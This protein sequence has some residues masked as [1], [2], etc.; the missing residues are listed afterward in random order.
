MLVINLSYIRKN[1]TLLLGILITLFLCLALMPWESQNPHVVLVTSANARLLPIYAVDA[2][3][4]KIAISF[5]ATWGAEETPKILAT[6]K[7]YNIKTTFFLVNIWLKKFP[8]M[9]KTIA[10]DGHEIGMHST[11]HPYF[12]KLSSEQMK[13][14]LRDNHAMIKQIC[15]YDAKLFRPPFGDYDNRVIATVNELGFQT[16]QWSADS[17][18]W[19]D[20][21]AQA[22]SDRVMSRMKPGAIVLF[23]NNGKHTAEAIETIIPALL[24][25]GYTIVPISNL[26]HKQNF[27]IDTNGIQRKK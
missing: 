26:I 14:E 16:I 21:S 1:K 3:D 7:K 9:T 23:H 22:I 10:A 12:T 19:K 18:D 27:F 20:L 8:D 13:Q 11:T 4:K 15:N 6:L 24:K 17:L 2:P 5:D 25:D